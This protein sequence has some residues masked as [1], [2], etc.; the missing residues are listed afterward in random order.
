MPIIQPTILD[1]MEYATDDLARTFVGNSGYD[2]YTKLLLK[3]DGSGQTVIDSALGKSIT[4]VGASMTQS[5][6]QKMFGAGSLYF[7]GAGDYLTTPDHADWQFGTG[8]FTLDFWVRFSTVAQQVCFFMQYAGGNDYWRFSWAVATSTLRFYFVTGGT[9]RADFN[10]PFSPSINTWYHITVVRNGSTCLMM[11][12]GDSKTVTTVTAFNGNLNCAGSVLY[13]M[14]YAGDGTRELLGYIDELRVSKGIAR[15]TG[16]FTKPAVPYARLFD[17]YSEATIKQE[18]SYSLK[19]IAPITTSLNKTLTRTVSPTINLTDKTIIKF[20][21]RA[22]RTGANIK[23]GIHDSGG[24]T[25]EITPTIVTADTWQT[26][27]WDISAVAN[28]I[29]SIIVTIV[30]ADAENTFYIDNMFGD[31]IQNYLIHR[32][33]DRFRTAGISLGN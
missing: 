32:G 16:S 27:V 20:D 12:D 21:I 9:V 26:V 24:T 7:D 22:S 19:G 10:C 23:I 4:V 5:A 8:N 6:A 18:G 28:A 30:N 31:V 25:T 3:G 17:A 14:S 29:D 15:W 11:V 33:R 1:L 2:S 13:I